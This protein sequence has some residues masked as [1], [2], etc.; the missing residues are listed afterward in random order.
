MFEIDVRATI[1]EATR[2]LDAVQRKQIPFATVLALTRS[3]KRAQGN[4]A[5][6]I[7]G[8]FDRPT[9]QT[10][11]A[12][13][14]KAATKARPQ[15]QVFLKDDFGK[16]TPA[17]KYLQAQIAG[18]A[19]AA[20]RF[21]RALQEAGILPRGWVTVPGAGERLDAYG[22]LPR[23]VITQILVDLRAFRADGFKA[24]RLT[25]REARETGKRYRRSRFFVVLPGKRQQP[26]IYRRF[27][28]AFG[29]GVRPVV[30][31]ARTSAYRPRLKF[32]DIVQRSIARH[33]PREFDAALR[34]ALRTA[35]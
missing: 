29:T 20:K 4:V 21:E 15:A 24:N 19:R 35:R 28:T 33:F 32:A 14:I 1:K 25:K 9:T 13:F 34:D 16:G 27:D 10:Q 3:A 18:G 8:S 30:I 7:R 6:A 26:G 11:R 17:A 31:F 5:A 23:G 12:T 22:N 2:E